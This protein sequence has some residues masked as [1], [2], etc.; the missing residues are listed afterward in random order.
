MSE[1]QIHRPASANGTAIVG[2]VHGQ[3]PPLVLVH[4]GP[5]D[6]DIAWEALVRLP[7]HHFTC[8]V[9]S[10]RGRGLSEDSQDHAPPRLEV[11]NTDFGYCP[12]SRHSPGIQGCPSSPLAVT[13][14]NLRW[15]SPRFW[16]VR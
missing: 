5:H 6:G 1:E 11:H 16:R 13:D 3:E 15:G 14:G 7:S 9:P 2:R 12:T 10:V 8:F 4:G